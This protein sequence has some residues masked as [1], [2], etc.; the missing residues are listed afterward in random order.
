MTLRTDLAIES[1]AGIKPSDGVGTATRTEGGCK[2]TETRILTD[3][4]A[5]KTGKPKGTYLTAE[6]GNIAQ[7]LVEAGGTA[8]VL[9]RLLCSIL[10]P[11]SSALVIGLGNPSLT[12]DALGPRT[13]N[14][15][16]ATRHIE[17]ALAESIGLAGLNSVSVLSPGVLG[18]TGM[19]AAE[20][21]RAAVRTVA[22]DVVI[23]IDALAA[24]DTARL[25]TTV[26]MNNFGIAPGAG[27]GNR[28]KEISQHTLGIPVV[29]VGVPTV[30]ATEN[31]N[32]IITSREIDLLIQRASELLSHAI[33]FSLQQEID[34]DILL[35]LV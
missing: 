4:A 31:E 12:A 27:V 15:V 9:C 34:R 20:V 32:L 10:P 18:Q 8:D 17:K 13:A 24:A 7:G 26:Q 23:V 21:V 6:V 19:E 30:T 2:I 22:P 33:N 28:R 5:E 16:L 3:S 14:G 11:F 1:A 25:G 35:S 29:A